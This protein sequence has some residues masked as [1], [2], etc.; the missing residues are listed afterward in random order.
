MWILKN[1]KELLENLKS[2]GFSDID[3]IKTYAFSILYTTIL[4]N[5]LKARHFQIIDNCFL[6]INGTRKYKFLV[7]GKQD[8]VFPR[9]NAI[10]YIAIPAYRHQYMQ[11]GFLYTLIPPIYRHPRLSPSPKHL[12]E[13]KVKLPLYF[14]R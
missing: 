4:H 12:Q 9:Y 10:R 1:S 3:N 6:N 8:I 7:I 11:N 14:P 2:R 5:K 13:Q